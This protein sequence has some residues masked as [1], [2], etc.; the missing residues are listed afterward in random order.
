MPAATLVLPW[1]IRREEA[2]ESRE[3]SLSER[4]AC[5][6]LCFGVIPKPVLEDG[7]KTILGFFSR[8]FAEGWQAVFGSG[9]AFTQPRGI[10]MGTCWR[11]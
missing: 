4:G 1:S 8:G 3:T 11:A 10:R 6:F 5:T 2:N 7:L 9:G